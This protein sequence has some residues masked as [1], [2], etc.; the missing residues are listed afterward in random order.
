[1]VHVLATQLKSSVVKA[2]ISGTLTKTISATPS[3]SDTISD[4]NVPFEIKDSWKWVSFNTVFDFQGGFAFKSGNYVDCSKNQVI[5]LGNVKNDL[6][7]TESKQ[8][9]ISDE[10]ARIAEKYKIKENDILITMT[11]TRGKKDYLFTVLVNEK[12]NKKHLYL[13]QRVG[14][15]RCKD[16]IIPAY[17]IIVLKCE[18]IL[19]LV[20]EHE[21]GTANQG[22]IGTSELKNYLYVPLP[23]IEEQ[24]RIVARVDELMA[25]IDEY[26]KL[27]NELVELKKNF[28]GDMKA[29]VLQAAMQGKLTEQSESDSNVKDLLD[30]IPNHQYVVEDI[31]D[32]PDKWVW[33]NAKEVSTIVVGATPSTANVNYYTDGNIVWLPSGCCQDCEVT[34]DNS[35]Y[36]M[37]TKEAYDSCSTKL[38]PVD[39]VLIALTGATTG[40]VGLLKIEACANQSVVGILPSKIMEP[41]FIYYHMMSRRN[42]ILADCVGSAQPHV[43]KNYITKMNF[44]LPP[45]E[46]QKRIVEKLDKILPLC[47]ELEKEIA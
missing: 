11:G 25:K 21:T 35:P 45:I 34:T 40:K 43:S 22:N 31:Y 47:E 28:P 12:Y 23:P 38:M 18:E 33:V 14:C 29:A 27:E 8:V 2:A 19:D 36:K 13:N 7:I 3:I 30:T 1:M 37:I 32:I 17:A 26:E 9:F 20:F 39:T 4:S 5:R 41:K 6:L 44:P 42:S 24:V 10:D 46:E 15:F 16:V